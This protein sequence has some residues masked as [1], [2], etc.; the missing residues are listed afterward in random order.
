[1]QKTLRPP[2]PVKKGSKVYGGRGIKILNTMVKKG[3]GR[4]GLINKET[5]NTNR[6]VK[7]RETLGKT[8]GADFEMEKS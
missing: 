1:M 7:E 4:A 6:K 5:D 3:N 2:K 8:V